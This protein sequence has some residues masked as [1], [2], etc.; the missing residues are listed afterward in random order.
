MK[1]YIIILLLFVGTLNTTAQTKEVE[2]TIESVSKKWEFSDLINPKF[3]KEK[4]EETKEMLESTMIE[5]RK[6][7]T[8]TF[9]FIV[10]LEGTWSLSQNVITTTDRRGKN[11]WTIHNISSNEIIMSRNDTEQK[12]IFKSE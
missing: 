9:S 12:L 8:F 2:I 7:M 3:T 11:T 1:N 6:D 5:F 4:Y 10:D